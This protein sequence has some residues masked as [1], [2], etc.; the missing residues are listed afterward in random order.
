MSTYT[1]FIDDNLQQ[2]SDQVIMER[3]PKNSYAD[4]TKIPILKKKLTAGVDESFY[5]T[6]EDQGAEGENENGINTQVVQIKVGKQ[7]IPVF[8]VWRTVIYTHMQMMQFDIAKKSGRAGALD[9]IKIARDFAMV[10]MMKE[11]NLRALL[12][13]REQGGLLDSITLDP[14]AIDLYSDA[15]N[16]EAIV[17]TLTKM[18]N[19]IMTQNVIED[20]S[21]PFA[22]RILDLPSGMRQVMKDRKYGDDGT[23][24]LEDHVYKRYPSIKKIFY[25]KLLDASYLESHGVLPVGTNQDAAL[26]YGLHPEIQNR[27]ITGLIKIPS[28]YH[29]GEYEST[30]GLGA[31]VTNVIR[32]S[33]M[34][35]IRFAKPTI[36]P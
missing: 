11:L 33:Y 31:T 30:I 24:S 28:S 35:G 17:R 29:R 2:D 26:C 23:M 3:V 19:D 25:S 32:K 21:D 8:Y 22:P 5:T 34:R 16:E 6:V 10:Q 1:Q 14:V 20:D 4:G 18:I 27:Q 13:L 7:V 36:T 9:F 12:G 15:T